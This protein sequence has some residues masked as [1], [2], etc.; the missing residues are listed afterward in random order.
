MQI[1]NRENILSFFLA[2]VVLWFGYQ[3]VSA[4]ENWVSLVPE[5]FGNGENLRY[6][7]LAHGAILILSG[8]FL[9]FNFKRRIAAGVIALML[10]GIIINFYQTGGIS[11]TLIRDVGLLGMALGLLVNRY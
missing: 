2:V 10:L 8:L 5:F 3:E 1:L 9:I 7:V 11:A 6:M 4:P